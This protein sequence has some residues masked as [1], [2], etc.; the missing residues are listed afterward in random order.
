MN[1]A[2]FLKDPI[3]SFSESVPV[4]WFCAAWKQRPFRDHVTGQFVRAVSK[5]GEF[6]LVGSLVPFVRA[7]LKKTSAVALFK[8][9]RD[10]S[11]RLELEWREEYEKLFPEFASSLPRPTKSPY[12]P[13]SIFEIIDLDDPDTVEEYVHFVGL[14]ALRQTVNSRGETAVEYARRLG[15]EYMIE[16][17][18]EQFAEDA[19]LE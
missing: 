1:R 8:E 9:I 10:A 5:T 7:A 19:S 4:D 17:I 16:A 2:E 3:R 11:D 13:E 6:G 14:D 15:A 18:E 12:R